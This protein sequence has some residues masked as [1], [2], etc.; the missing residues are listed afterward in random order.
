MKAYK[1]L[2]ATCVLISAQFYVSAQTTPR[3][4]PHSNNGNSGQPGNYNNTTT[5]PNYNNG[6]I[7]QPD[8]NNGTLNPNYN[9]STI[10]TPQNST[11]NEQYPNGN[12]N[13]QNPD[14]NKGT[15]QTPQNS[16]GNQQTPN[17]N[18]N[19]QNPDD[20]NRRMDGG[21]IQQ[22]QN[23]T[24]T[25]T[26]TVTRQTP[27]QDSVRITRNKTTQKSN[28]TS[29][30]NRVNT[31]SKSSTNYNQQHSKTDIVKDANGNNKAVHHEKNTTVTK[32]DTL[33]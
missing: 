2:I 12:G 20:V 30:G 19:W 1:I 14:F 28:H 22:N 24:S 8:N 10:Q 11:G 26:T 17:G 33:R 5:N 27:P 25:H 7:Q 23:N 32:K 31:G 21:V 3:N 9:N 16:T 18:N 4:E 6:N 15:I 29:T 13:N